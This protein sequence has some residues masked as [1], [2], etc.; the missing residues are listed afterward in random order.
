MLLQILS[1]RDP[2]LKTSA[3]NALESIW[4]SV[5]PDIFEKM[6]SKFHGREKEMIE[7]RIKRSK[8]AGSH[9][10]QTKDSTEAS[11]DAAL[12]PAGMEERLVE[13]DIREEMIYRQEYTPPNAFDMTPELDQDPSPGGIQHPPIAARTPAQSF[14]PKVPSTNEIRTP[15]PEPLKITPGV[16]DRK[17]YP[18]TPSY[19]EEALEARW[20]MNLQTMSSPNLED[21]INATKQICSDITLVTSNKNPPPSDRVCAIFGSTADRFFLVICAQLEA[22]FAE[23]RRHLQLYPSGP[24]PSSR[25]C[26]FALNAL[27]Q[28]LGVRDLAHSV[29]QPTLRETICLLLCSLVDETGLLS[30]EEGPTLVRAVNVLIARM[31]ES[32]DKNY[33][34][35]SLLLLLRSPPRNLDRQ[36]VP[37]YNDLVV[38]CLIK[39]TKSLETGGLHDVDVTDLLLYLHDYFMFLGVEEIRKR[40]AAEDKPLRM[41]KTILHQLCKMLGYGVYKYANEIP[42]RHSQPQ[43]IIFR[44]IE[45]NLNMLKEINQLPQQQEDEGKSVE[46]ER[47]EP[48]TRQHRRTPSNPRPEGSIEDVKQKLKEVLTSVVSRDEEEKRNALREL[49]MIKQ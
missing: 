42:G 41:V 19:D 1:E 33:A 29:P 47:L 16:E 14:M 8:K 43:P 30:F 27:L 17:Q 12:T 49:L 36:L 40:S 45:I 9:A 35:S 22:I 4:A 7:D 6:L 24:P 34:F 25:G 46:H 23:A 44:Y 13:E 26:K 39:L 31:L 38:K 11:I 48:D 20:E 32:V 21:A 5:G 10:V 18:S 3:L 15:V 28:G 37:K 2:S